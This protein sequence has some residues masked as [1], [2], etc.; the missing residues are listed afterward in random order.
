MD[1]SKVTVNA[2]SATIKADWILLP[3]AEVA[4]REASLKPDVAPIR[5][6]LKAGKD[7]KTKPV[8][9]LAPTVNSNTVTSISNSRPGI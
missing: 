3:E 8:R 9:T 1:T 6:V 4:E 2:T 5:I 7:P